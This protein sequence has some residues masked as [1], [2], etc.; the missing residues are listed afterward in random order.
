MFSTPGFNLCLFKLNVGRKEG[1]KE[2]ERGCCII[3][4]CF[5]TSQLL[6]VSLYSTVLFI[7]GGGRK[8][9]EPKFCAAVD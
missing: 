1:G 4:L 8:L 5:V 2:A 9:D 7:I 6:V 3:E